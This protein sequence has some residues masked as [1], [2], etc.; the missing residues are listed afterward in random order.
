MSISRWPRR[1]GG[2]CRAAVVPLVLAGCDAPPVAWQD[3]RPAGAAP[4]AADSSFRLAV[5]ERGGLDA[6]AATP[7]I[8]GGEAPFSGCP[9]SARV[10][11]ARGGER[12]AAWWR[13]RDDSSA[14]L[15]VARSADGGATW[16]APVAVDTLDRGVRACAR[17]A[18]AI[19]ADSAN[20]FVHVVYFLD[21]PEGSGL[22][23]AHRMD[24]RAPFEPPAV[25]VYGERPVAAAVASSG[26]RVVVAYEDPNRPRPQIELALSRTAGHLFEER[27][28]DVS[29][30]DVAARAPRVALGGDGRLWVGWT[31]GDGD[32]RGASV[33]REGRLQ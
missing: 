24:P 33:V 10:A 3:A 29:G 21:A 30:D 27:H 1:L 31:E 23:Y 16:G 19:A 18:P 13:V 32:G 8:P 11:A 7:P 6:P 20:G 12:Y 28:V 15:L 26:D 9:G 4:G 14:L 22:F 5:V 25:I 17:P 2:V